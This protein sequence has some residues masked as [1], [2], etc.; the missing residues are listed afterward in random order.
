MILTF[1]RWKSTILDTTAGTNHR[2]RVVARCPA[3]L[4]YLVGLLISPRNKKEEDSSQRLNV[5]SYVLLTC[6]IIAEDITK[7]W[8]EGT[9]GTRR[10]RDLPDMMSGRRFK[11]QIAAVMLNASFVFPQRQ[12][13]AVTIK[14]RL[15][16]V[17]L[18]VIAGMGVSIFVVRLASEVGETSQKPNDSFSEA[19]A[20]VVRFAR[21]R[22]FEL[23]YCAHRNSDEESNGLDNGRLANKT[24]RQFQASSFRVSQTFRGWQLRDI[25]WEA[26]SATHFHSEI[27]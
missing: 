23:D 10:G 24:R 17:E 26:T 1:A 5:D 4:T 7:T 8:N 3:S 18:I 27:R 20:Q 9:L 13:P 21:R 11:M 19:A 12:P 2:K 22:H 25:S 16:L 15:R 6:L 14:L